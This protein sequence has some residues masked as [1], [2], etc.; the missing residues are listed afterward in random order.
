[1]PPIPLAEFNKY[2][3]QAQWTADLR[4]TQQAAAEA[5]LDQMTLADINADKD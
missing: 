2:L 4:Q 1:M 3:A 5:Q